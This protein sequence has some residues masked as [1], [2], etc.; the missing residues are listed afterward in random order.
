MAAKLFLASVLLTLGCTRPDAP[1]SVRGVYVHSF[2]ISN[3]RECGG[4]S[5]AWVDRLQT[6]PSWSKVESAIRSGPDGKTAYV[7][8]NAHIKG[9]GRYGRLSQ[10]WYELTPTVVS[11]A[12]AEVPTECRS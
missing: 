9:P 3:F 4:W 5:T 6:P 7:E 8:M 11:L 12:K 10:Y 2:E 1:Q